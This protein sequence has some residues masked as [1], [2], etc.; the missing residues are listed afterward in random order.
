MA[1]DGMKLLNT[2][3]GRV[4]RVA[5]I[6]HERI[7]YA[8]LSHR[9]LKEDEK[10]ME[11]VY[12]DLAPRGER[13]HE[14]KNIR[15]SVKERKIASFRKLD[16]AAQQARQQGLNY[17]WIDTV[18]IDRANHEEKHNAIASMYKWYQQSRICF[19]YLH[20]VSFQRADYISLDSDSKNIS[21]RRKLFERGKSEWF[22]RYWTL[23]ELI[24]SRNRYI[25]NESWAP[26]GTIGYKNHDKWL[27][28]IIENHTGIPKR[29]LQGRV[30]LGAIPLATRMLWAAP[31][32]TPT[33][34]EDVAY[35]LAGILE[36]GNLEIEEEIGKKRAFQ[37][38]L[39]EVIKAHPHDDSIFACCGKEGLSHLMAS[40]PA[41]FGWLRDHHP[42]DLKQRASVGCNARI[43]DRGLEVSFT[44]VRETVPRRDLQAHR[45]YRVYLNYYRPGAKDKFASFL[46]V[47]EKHGRYFRF[48]T[49]EMKAKP[50][51]HDPRVLEWHRF[52]VS[53]TSGDYI[54]EWE[55]DSSSS[56]SEISFGESSSLDRVIRN[57]IHRPD[58]SNSSIQPSKRFG[59][60]P[61]RSDAGSP[62]EASASSL[63]HPIGVQQ[64]YGPNHDY[65]GTPP[66]QIDIWMP[67]QHPIGVQQQYGP[68][69]DYYGTPPG[70]TDEYYKPPESYGGIRNRISNTAQS[71]WQV[72]VQYTISSQDQPAL[73]HNKPAGMF[74]RNGQST[75]E[76]A[77]AQHQGESST[78]R[79]QGPNNDPTSCNGEIDDDLRGLP[80]RR[81]VH[82]SIALMRV[83]LETLLVAQSH[84]IGLAPELV[85]LGGALLTD[86]T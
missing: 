76:I 75:F 84:S 78:A 64:Q 68:N 33:V 77:P 4:E 54:D 16:S 62:P 60:S 2:K 6:P 80:W 63:Q 46:L 70:Q 82:P 18:C 86:S 26:I 8:I 85:S 27:A 28:E 38:L 41:D 58:S 23:Q 1:D 59:S 11:I 14:L 7:Q 66:G 71:A 22:K 55:P 65:Y 49:T 74:R 51:P 72:Y 52:T 36:V 17:I 47:E 37:R 9:W 10:H 30:E 44:A 19:V 21:K 50:G 39:K 25:V 24:A 42:S 83:I 13:Y 79:A 53:P 5:D 20:D 48:G 35:S 31:R 56:E 45:A 57:Q 73:L 69:H 32:H 61:V 43:T 29:Y 67:L 81:P 40:S 12:K 34:E 3:S 15:E